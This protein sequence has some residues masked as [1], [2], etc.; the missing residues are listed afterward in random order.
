MESHRT[1]KFTCFCYLVCS[2]KKYNAWPF[3]VH[4]L[5]KLK[6]NIFL[7]TMANLKLA[8]FKR[9]DQNNPGNEAGTSFPRGKPQFLLYTQKFLFRLTNVL[10]LYL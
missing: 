3:G 2:D 6:F 4:I 8:K 9:N 5:Q 1:L 10:D 7:Q